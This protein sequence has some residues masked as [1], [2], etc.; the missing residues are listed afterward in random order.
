MK[1]YPSKETQQA[2]FDFF[3]RTSAPRLL[4]KAK[5]KELE[6]YLIQEDDL[7]HKKPQEREP[8]SDS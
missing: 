1:T 2:M 7:M 4:A 3:M 8:F 5:A 6:D